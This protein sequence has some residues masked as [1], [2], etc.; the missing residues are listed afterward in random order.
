[1]NR[2]P[3]M[4]VRALYDAL[5]ERFG[6][7]GRATSPPA[8]ARSRVLYHLL[9]ALCDPGD[10]VVYAWRSFEAYPIAVGSPAPPSVQVPLTAAAGMTSARC[11]RQSPTAPSVVLVCTPNNPTGPAVRA[12]RARRASSRTCPPTCS[13]SS[14]RR[15]T[16]SSAST[17]PPT[18]S[19]CTAAATQR[20][21]APHVLQGLRAGWFPGRVRGRADGGRRGR[22]QVRSALRGLQVAQDAAVASLEAEDALLERVEALVAERTRVREALC[23]QGWDVPERAGQLRLADPRRGLALPSPPRARRSG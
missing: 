8:P 18:G 10:E 11:S 22:A 20:V 13:S 14:T 23:E 4:G 5:A 3:D 16:S 2:Y 7:A 9:Q 17:I 19:S 1:M 21:R 12:R 6:V 15:T